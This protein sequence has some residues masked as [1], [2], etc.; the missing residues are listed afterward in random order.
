MLDG[1]WQDEAALMGLTKETYE[2]FSEVTQK[3][4]IE[5]LTEKLRQRLTDQLRTNTYTR[6]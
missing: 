3:W 6:D 1:A 5:A 2:L 4:A